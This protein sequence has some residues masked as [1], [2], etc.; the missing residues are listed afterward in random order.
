VEIDRTHR[1]PARSSTSA[2]LF[3][4]SVNTLRPSRRDDDSH[5][6]HGR[7]ASALKIDRVRRVL[8]FTCCQPATPDFPTRTMSMLADLEHASW[9]SDDNGNDLYGSPRKLVSA[10]FTS[11]KIE[12]T[13][14]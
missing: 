5:F 6:Y 4:M 1:R 11:G 9:T 12:I 13:N 8:D 3:T 10:V 2:R 7:V 14:C